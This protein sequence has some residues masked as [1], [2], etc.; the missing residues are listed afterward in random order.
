MEIEFFKEIG[1]K[2]RK[3]KLCGSTFW[4][5]EEKENCGDI[6]CGKY[7]FIDEQIIKKYNDMSSMRSAFIS[8]FEKRNHKKIDRYP[9]IARWRDDVF[10]VNASIYDFQPH[11]TSGLVPPPANPLVISQPCIRFVDLDYVGFSGRH[12]SNFEMMAHHAFNSKDEY[13]Y[14]DEE[15]ARYCHD[16]LTELG[17]DERKVA[18]KETPWVGGGNAGNA[19]EVI[20]AGLELAT[21]VFMDL[22][23]DENGTIVIGDEKFSPM[24]MKIVDTGYGLERFLWCASQKKNI[25]EAV[26]PEVLDKIKEFA[27]ILEIEK[28]YAIADHTRAL[29]ILLCDGVV[30]SNVKEGYL[31]RHIIRRT[32]RLMEEVGISVP[33]YEIVF[34]HEK[35]LEGIV[36][37]KK[38]R[39]TIIEIL[40]LEK[41][42]YKTTLEKGEKLVRRLLSEKK[43]I[44]DDDLIDYYDTYGLPPVVVEKICNEHN[45]SIIIPK[46]FN[47]L[48]AKRHAKVDV[49]I[50]EEEE[51]YEVEP[52]ELLYYKDEK[53]LEFNAKV[54]YSSGNEVVLDRTAFYP[55]G[56]GQGCDN[57]IFIV[58]GKEVEVR[59]VRKVGSVVVHALSEPVSKNSIVNCKVNEERRE[60]HKRHHTATHIIIG[61]CRAL[62]GEHIWQAGAQKFEDYGRI[63][64][65]HYSKLDRDEVKKLE[66][67]ANQIVMKN[68]KIDK[69]FL[70]RDEAEKKYGFRLYQGG[71][72]LTSKIR[73]VKIGDFD[74]QACGGTHCAYTSEVGVIKILKTERI[75]DGVVRIEFSAG[76]SAI[77]RIQEVE[78]LVNK[79]CDIFGIKIENLPRI[80]K[81][82]FDE[83]KFLKKELEK[84]RK[85]KIEMKE[86][87]IGDIKLIY[88]L[89]ELNAK[90][91][92][93]IAGKVIEEENRI[94]IIG[95]KKDGSITVARSK[96]LNIN[97]AEV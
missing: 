64:I 87:V 67:Y 65:T 97:C 28:I 91:I 84:L 3:C 40:E 76:I 16:F 30:P 14:W 6:P 51:A 59:E 94:A 58:N 57:G 42:R 34:L 23:S 47:K 89:L 36:S 26:Y 54:I 13:I 4:S 2:K 8:F 70:N 25:Y 50:K 62:F 63:D 18:Y 15:T 45:I 61:A 79:A 55:E 92:I 88:A 10:F 71:A 38:T 32:L 53:L 75:Q 29:G 56:G 21:L 90:E 48:V 68:L 7:E 82:F 86:D 77:K 39:N 41:E 69:F 52:T 96:N 12:L 80:A 74:V 31:V 1:A 27:K 81:K 85:E 95:G 43:E 17:V 49:K 72:P 35:N 60:G 93:P 73:I 20:V 5:I 83:W 37:L 33:I 46:N 19:L 44:K 11:C 78:E 24:K 66:L 22:K 9:V